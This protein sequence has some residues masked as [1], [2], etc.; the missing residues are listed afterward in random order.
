MTVLAWSNKPKVLALLSL[1]FTA[2]LLHAS[3][4]HTHKRYGAQ[5]LIVQY[6]KTSIGATASDVIML[7][8]SIVPSKAL[9]PRMYMILQAIVKY[10]KIYR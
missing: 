6:K 7:F 1:S 9:V 2:G 10:I 8:S 3:R 4:K 5:K